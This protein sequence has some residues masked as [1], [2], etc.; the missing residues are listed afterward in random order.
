MRRTAKLLGVHRTTIKRKL[1]Y[2]SRIAEKS[3]RSFLNELQE[4]PCTELWLD[5]LITIEHTKLKPLS[6]SVL[7]DNKR[8]I[9]GMEVSQIPAFGH[10]A[11]ISRRK[12][13]Y[14]KSCLKQGLN[15]LF[16]NCKP[17]IDI[18]ATIRSD[19][20]KLYR[21]VI[22]KFLPEVEH[23]QFKSDPA[24]VAGQGE[25]KKNSRDPLFYINHTLAM[26]RANISRLIRRT[27]STTKD[28]AMLQ[29]HL[30]VYLQYH[31]TQLI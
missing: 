25:L 21:P 8:R 11:K 26:L 18:H 12:Y 29:Q 1:M 20:H 23:L 15:R 19:E 27:W 4:N 13:G 7:V 2:L 5:D 28:P 22:S 14:R 17:A 10:L 6:V 3:Q 16:Q 31:N 9:L 24:H 30:N